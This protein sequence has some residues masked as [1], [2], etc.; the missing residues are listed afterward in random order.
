[1][2]LTS[3]GLEEML[4]APGFVTKEQFESVKQEARQRNIS[5]EEVLVERGLIQ[6]EHLGRLIAERMGFNFVDLRRVTI[7]KEILN[8]IPEEVA[9][10]QQVI[11]FD[12]VSEGIKVAMTD[13]NNLE[14]I[15]WL[16]RK[17]NQRIIPY[18]TT[19]RSIKVAL[20]YFHQQVKESFEDVVNQ[21]LKRIKSGTA[22]AETAVIKIVDAIIRYGY[23]NE[24]SDIHIEPMKKETIVRY[25]IDG[26]LRRGLTL[27]RFVHDSIVT[28]IKVLSNLRI[29]E[30]FAA[31]D[32]RFT[33]T[34]GQ[35][36]FDARVS[37]IPI[38]AGEK[39]ELRLLSERARKFTLDSLGL[40]EK[41]IEI[42]KE[43]TKKSYGMLIAG[44]P[45]GCGK[46]TTMYA[47]L[48]IL[49]TPEVNISSIEDPVEYYIPGVNQV[50]VNP[51]T[52]LT[53]SQGLRSIVR[54]DP[55]IILVGEIRDRETVKIAIDTAMTGHLVLSTMH[56]I[57][58]AANL[59]RL[60]EMG[61]EPYLV[62]SSV[63]LV[64]A[65]RL[66]RKICPACIESYELKKSEA[67]SKFPQQVVEELFKNTDEVRLYRGRGCKNCDGTGYFGRIG[68][69]E[70]LE[71]KPNIRELI[72]AKASADRIEAQARKNGM[73][74]ML[75]DGIQKI[76]LGITTIEEIVRAL[77]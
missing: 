27:P 73:T 26:I 41:D 40:F 6:D 53:F 39:I 60:I 11:C 46:T 5:L 49:N 45:T 29:D 58:A 67:L 28:R 35:D 1:M 31:Q 30:H 34:I 32:G 33:V 15:D 54:Q 59:I 21:E 77:T 74:T 43:Y 3:K 44:G 75:E 9:K 38:T 18:Y 42:I 55:D 68:I 72:I 48:K 12:Q 22:G 37:V 4:V 16:E 57:N 24:A 64:I 71:V 17:T 50:Q 52:N 76:L 36:S 66:V 63:I 2:K 25:R 47:I 20:K 61:A 51:R 8:I 56:A 7:P 69:F 70:V 19:P 62:A 10:N 23:E 13:P 14:M 65:Q